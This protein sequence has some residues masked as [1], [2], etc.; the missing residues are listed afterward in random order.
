MKNVAV[1]EMPN[2]LAT[3]LIGM[4]GNSPL[5]VGFNEPQVEEVYH[6][7]HI[8]NNEVKSLIELME[9]QTNEAIIIDSKIHII[10]G[11]F[12]NP[13]LIGVQLEF[14]SIEVLS[15]GFETTEGD[16]KSIVNISCPFCTQI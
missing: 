5:M 11:L 14:F 4:V 15:D 2:L 8:V 16:L 9:T 10:E 12:G 1:L 3:Q 6:E 13:D 7:N